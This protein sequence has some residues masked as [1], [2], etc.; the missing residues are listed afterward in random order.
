MSIRGHHCGPGRKESMRN[1]ASKERALQSGKEFW[2]FSKMVERESKRKK[3]VFFTNSTL[4]RLHFTLSIDC[5]LK[6]IFGRLLFRSPYE[7]RNIEGGVKP[8]N[9]SRG[10]YGKNFL[11]N[12]PINSCV[13][14]YL[15]RMC[16][17]SW[18]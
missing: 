18:R 10:W 2:S 1:G 3:R 12:S 17:I 7:L 11:L 9:S 15:W 16:V 13:H 5:I 4:N 14:C 8:Y 6:F